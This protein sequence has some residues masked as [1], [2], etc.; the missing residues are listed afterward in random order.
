MCAGCRI[1]PACLALSV[2]RNALTGNLCSF[3]AFDLYGDATLRIV[4]ELALRL[5]VSIPFDSLVVCSALFCF[6]LN[7]LSF[8]DTIQSNT[9]Q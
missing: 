8:S 6:V 1:K 3:S 5:A 4:I 2:L 7:V 9:M